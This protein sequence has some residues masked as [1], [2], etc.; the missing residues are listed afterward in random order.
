M[1]FRLA[2]GFT[3]PP[4]TEG[5]IHGWSVVGLDSS[6]QPTFRPSPTP[7]NAQLSRSPHSSL[8][9]HHGI[10]SLSS[11]FANKP[12]SRF[13]IAAFSF[14]IEFW[15]VVSSRLYQ[16]RITC[17]GMRTKLATRFARV[18]Q[19]SHPH[20]SKPP[21]RPTT[22][23]SETTWSLRRAATSWRTDQPVFYHLADR[24]AGVLPAHHP[25][26]LPL[27]QLL[28]PSHTISGRE[29]HKR[30]KRKLRTALGG[31]WLLD[32]PASSDPQRGGRWR[33]TKVVIGW[34][35]HS[36]PPRHYIS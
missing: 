17:W 6:I 20:H 9:F 3:A 27:S 15:N 5:S 8:F 30:Y 11:A 21:R 10:R 22:T 7:L 35:N 14:E 29:M 19:W 36:T 1:T 33:E 23:S 12:R 24:P 18:Y 13:V 34:Q 28:P 4:A 32:A 2:W 26:S 25:V 16:P 31:H